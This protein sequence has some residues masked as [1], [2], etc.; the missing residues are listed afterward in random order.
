MSKTISPSARARQRVASH[1]RKFEPSS[2][3]KFYWE[4]NDHPLSSPEPKEFLGRRR[5][6][7][8]K[9][10]KKVIT[11]SLNGLATEYYDAGTHKIVK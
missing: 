11:N 7:N 9:E 4:V 3:R 1:C 8:N 5:S 6:E 10:L 2:I